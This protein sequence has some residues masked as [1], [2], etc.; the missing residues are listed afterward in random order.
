M[1]ARLRCGV[2]FLTITQLCPAECKVCDNSYPKVSQGYSD[3][4]KAQ[5]PQPPFQSEDRVLYG[6]PGVLGFLCNLDAPIL[7]LPHPRITPST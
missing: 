1:E 7:L 4:E 5:G 6:K 3:P 2:T